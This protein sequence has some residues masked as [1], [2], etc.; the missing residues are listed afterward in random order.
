MSFVE[1]VHVRDLVWSRFRNT[2]KLATSA[3][4]LALAISVPLGIIAGI[5]QGTWIDS[6][7]VTVAMLGVS[8]PNYWLGLMLIVVFCVKLHWLPSFG[9]GQWNQM[10]L[11]SITLGSALTAYTTKILRSAII[12]TLGSEYLLSLRAKGV[13]NRWILGRHILKNALIPVVTVVGIEFGMILEG[14]VITETIFAWP[15][16][17]M[18][19]V[20]AVSNRDYPLLQGVVLLIATVFVVINLMV[21][22]ICHVLNPRIKLT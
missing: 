13:E 11:P 12:D 8:V 2:V 22:I 10:I 1:E 7:S 15:G 5:R 6:M 18:L 20:D 19:L 17:G 14:A 21:D 4:I 16:L 3:I 9:S